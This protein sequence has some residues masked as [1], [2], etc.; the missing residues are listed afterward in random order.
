MDDSGKGSIYVVGADHATAHDA[1]T[2]KEQWRVGGLNPNQDGYFRSISSPVLSGDILI[3]P[4]ARGKSVTAIRVGG[5]GDV[6]KSHVA[7]FRE[8]LGADV[9]TPV[10]QNGRVY[11]CGDRGDVSCVDAKSGKEIWSVP[12]ERNR[13]PFSSSPVL[14]GSNL[15]VTREDGKT[16]VLSAEDGRAVGNGTLN[17]DMLV[18]TPTFADNCIY[19]RTPDSLYCIGKESKL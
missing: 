18:A 3:A 12:T 14:A 13:K 1:L 8:G 6:T 7:W 5:Q 15:Y 10:A 16:F 9:P 4:Y 19:F 11:V 2:G 17:T